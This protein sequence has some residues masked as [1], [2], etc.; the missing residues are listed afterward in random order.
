MVN[1][2][3]VSDSNGDFS[4]RNKTQKYRTQHTGPVS[5][6]TIDSSLEQSSPQPS[7]RAAVRPSLPAGR[8]GRALVRSSHSARWKFVTPHRPCVRRP[9]A[10]R[11]GNVTPPTSNLQCPA[12]ARCPWSV[13][14]WRCRGGVA[15][16]LP[17]RRRAGPPRLQSEPRP[18]PA[19]RSL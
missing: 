5:V 18:R 6:W 14:A 9:A 12:A 16:V 10:W 11:T 1:S 3:Q 13:V 7:R 8:R 15:N 2:Q 4:S 17:R 19:V